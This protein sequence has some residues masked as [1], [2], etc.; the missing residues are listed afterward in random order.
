MYVN[1]KRENKKLIISHIADVDGLGAVILAKVHFGDID[2]CLVDYSELDEAMEELVKSGTYHKYDEIFVTDLSLRQG[3]IDLIE[4]NEEL[5]SKIKHFDHH[6]SEVNQGGKYPFVNVQY[7]D[8]DG[9]LVC[10][11]TMFYKHIEKDFKYKSEYLDKFLEGVRS[12]DTMG[13]LGS[14]KYGNDLTTLS[15]LIKKE[16]FIEKFVKGIKAKEDSMTLDDK[17]IIDG[18]NQRV[19]NYI[20]SC[21]KTLVRIDL[22]GHRVGV[23][24][25][26][27][28]RSSVG[29]ELSKKYYDDL[30][31]ILIINF[32]RRQFSFRTVRDDV[33]VG[34]IAKHFCSSGG[35]QPKA[36]GMPINSD[37]LFIL[38]LVRDA[39][40]KEEYTRKMIQ[41]N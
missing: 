4:G 20:D 27:S 7:T 9:K 1:I 35:G 3:S 29:S 16:D 28:Y 10:G 12:H 32:M 18:E 30:D 11:T 25:S 40:I 34:Q 41:K 38:D 15:C 6:L 17:M 2:Y 33:D 14:S 8:E 13:P 22:D 26:E 19:K 37:T 36:A 39:L 5:K 31:Y 23:S 24:I 21:D